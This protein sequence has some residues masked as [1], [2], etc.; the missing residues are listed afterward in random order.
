MEEFINRALDEDG[1]VVI[2]ESFMKEQKINP[3][4]IANKRKC[5]IVFTPIDEAYTIIKPIF[6]NVNIT[7]KPK[8][9]V[10]TEVLQRI[11]VKVNA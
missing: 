4:H 6:W 3:H 10:Y 11:G 5:F 2:T 7:K 9:K 8:P 1:Y